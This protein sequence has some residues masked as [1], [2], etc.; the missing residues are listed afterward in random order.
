[1]D[2]QGGMFNE[3]GSEAMDWEEEADNPLR[4]QTLTSLHEWRLHQMIIEPAAHDLQRVDVVMTELEAKISS[5]RKVYNN[6]SDEQKALFL[7]LLKFRFLKAKP[8][9]ERA[10]IN[11]RTAQ[12]WAKRMKEDPEWD[13][14]EKL[15]NKVNRAGSQLQVEHKHFLMNLFDEEPQAT[16]QDVVDALT[17]AF[18]GFSLK[19]SQVGTFIYN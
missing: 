15:T 16:R 11:V 9:A 18:E 14:Y 17:A 19:A 13:I 2:G 8:A 6:Y 1:E 12:G 3:D 7:Y 10:L 5:S 4:T